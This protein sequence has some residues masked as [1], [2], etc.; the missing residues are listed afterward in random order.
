MKSANFTFPMRWVKIAKMY[1][2][3]P[4]SSTVIFV[5]LSLCAALTAI[6]FGLR[7]WEDNVNAGQIT[8]PWNESI[9]MTTTR[10]DIKAML[11]GNATPNDPR[12]V[13]NPH[14]V[15]IAG[16]SLVRELGRYGNNGSKL[17][18]NPPYA[19]YTVCF[20]Q[21]LSGSHKGLEGWIPSNLMQRKFAPP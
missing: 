5:G 2:R 13:L 3:T 12:N 15:L 7:Q 16:G 21:I 9:V 4:K 14:F 20:V 10:E 17:I 19:E 11:D 18:S 6:A 1:F 8:A